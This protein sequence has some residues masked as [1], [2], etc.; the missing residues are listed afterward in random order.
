MNL[1][2]RQRT[3]RYSYGEDPDGVSKVVRADLARAIAS[4]EYA[5]DGCK[6]LSDIHANHE[7]APHMDA[8]IEMR[9]KAHRAVG[10]AQL[11]LKELE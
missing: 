10:R 11:I 6:A 5:L 9:E 3:A 8:L 7:K 1:R 2:P 4:L